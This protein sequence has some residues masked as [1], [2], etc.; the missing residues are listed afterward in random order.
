MNIHDK[1]NIRQLAHEFPIIG[2]KEMQERFRKLKIGQSGD[3]MN[4]MDFR[5]KVLVNG[6]IV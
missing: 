1:I 5:G 3:L 2:R 4:Q 6:V